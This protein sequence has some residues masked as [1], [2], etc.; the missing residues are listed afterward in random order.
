FPD[1]N[2]GTLV[3]AGTL[4]ATG[5]GGMVIQ[6]NVIENS[7]Q[8]IA[9]NSVLIAEG[10]VTGK[11]TALIEGTGTIEFGATSTANT[12]FARGADGTLILDASSTST[13]KVSVSG[14]A[15]G[16]TMDLAD[17]NYGVSGPSLTFKK[18]VLIVS[19]GANTAEIKMVGNFT[20]SSFHA[21]PDNSG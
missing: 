7:G 9:N 12:T 6:Y 2:P 10:A 13:G 1:F 16:D 19:D 14:F 17:I 3:N 20:Q 15:P 8:L 21:A 11:G 4:E 5:T 18:G